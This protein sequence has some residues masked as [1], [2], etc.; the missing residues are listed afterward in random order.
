[1]ANVII[2]PRCNRRVTCDAS[3]NNARSESALAINPLDP[4]NMVGSSKRFTNPSKYEFSLAAYATFD[5]GLSWIEAPT[6]GLLPG[7]AGISDP[8]VC[9]DN[10]GNAYLLA[11]PFPPGGG[12]ST[13]GIAVYKSTNGGRTWSAPN[14]I[15]SSGGDDKQWIDG[16]NNA[17]SPHFGKL[18]AAWDDGSTLAFPRSLDNGAT[19]RGTG[20]AI[21]PPGT[22]LASDSFSPEI[23]IADDGSVYIVYL[24]GQSGNRIKYVKSTDGGESFT[25]PLIA[26]DGVSSIRGAFP[27]PF[28]FPQFQG[29]SF[30][31]LTLAT[32]CAGSGNNVIFA[33]ADARESFGGQRRSRIYY[34]RSTNGGTTW[35]GPASGQPMLTGGNL[36]SGAHHDF[37]PQLIS[38]P[39]GEIGCAFYEYGPFG[40]GE[41]PSNLIDVKLAVSTDNGATFPNL[42]SVT[43]SPWNPNVDA[44]FSHG[45]PNLTFIG[46]Y[47]G[48][49]ASELGFFPLW[50]DTRTG[51]QEMFFSR[52]SVNPADTYIRDSSTDTGTVPSPGFHWEAPDLIIRRQKD[53][54]VT[55][56][57]QDLLRDGVTDHW[58]YARATNKGPH[59]AR[60]VR[61]AVTIGNYPSLQGLPGAEFRYPQYWYP[62]DWNTAALKNNHLFLGESDP[63]DIPNGATKLIGP[64]L[65]PAAQIPDPA[66]WHPCVLAEARADNNDAAGGVT[67]CDIQVDP[68]TC[69]YGAYFWGNNNICQRNLN[70]AKVK[71]ATAAYIELPFVVGSV[72]STAKFIDVIVEKGRVL[73]DTPMTLRMEPVKPDDRLPEPTCHPGELVFT[74]K[75]RVIVRVGGCEVGEI[76]T[77]EGTVWRP[78]CPPTETTH[79]TENPGGGRAEQIW[80]L[81]QP[82]SS[83]GFPITPGDVVRMTLSFTTPNTLK[84]GTI[85]QVHIIQRNDRRITTGSVILELEVSGDDADE[86]KPTRGGGGSKSTQATT[87]RT[88]RKNQTSQKRLGPTR[89]GPR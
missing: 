33:W 4:Y 58:V 73:S 38:T 65:W 10:L 1:M 64:V 74:G 15:H 84:P 76:V 80:Q 35:L 36:P 86:P 63:V 7:W 85:T 31:V 19:W 16:D 62:K 53:G 68:G 57:N 29:A 40:G 60:K 27:E 20:A 13:I 52:I 18:Y 48:L 8:S 30:R 83:A 25:A 5:G 87:K 66:V 75:C 61:L 46:E 55:F 67:G 41:F 42:V 77:T 56:V 89:L 34:R 71:P 51:V 79:Q 59:T 39:N 54:D 28:G 47:F 82:T 44:P 69:N 81:T 43:D 21:T 23:S 24:N 72:W 70:Y 88:S 12:F 37:H 45:D 14:L 3:P 32:G 2:G 49:D 11:L 78:H 9:W 6:L 17:A 22:S 26:A 50:T